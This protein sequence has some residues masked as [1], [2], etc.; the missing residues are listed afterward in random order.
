MEADKD[1]MNDYDV[2]ELVEQEKP[3]KRGRP[4]KVEVKAQEPKAEPKEDKLFL[5]RLL[6][7]TNFPAVR[8]DHGEEIVPKKLISPMMVVPYKQV[9]S[10]VT[11]EPELDKDYLPI[12]KEMGQPRAPKDGEFGENS[13]IQKGS[14]VMVDKKWAK[15][16][17]DNELAKPIHR[18]D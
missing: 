14:F 12:V 8:N 18:Y 6:K 10:D 16:F 1:S 7:G 4:T 5:F 17:T 11:N 9:I 2:S 13:K 15:H 3:K